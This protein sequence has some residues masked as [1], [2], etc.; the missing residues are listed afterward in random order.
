MTESPDDNPNSNSSDSAETDSSGSAPGRSEL[1]ALFEENRIRLERM[2]EFRLDERL[3]GRVDP[4]DIMQEAFIEADRRF[5]EYQARPAVSFYV[6]LRQI[7]YQ[8]LIDVQRRHFGKK[9]DPRQE[10]GPKRSAGD[11]G[12][13]LCILSAFFSDQ[14]S[15][16]EALMRQEEREQLTLLLEEMDEIDREVLALRHFEQLSNNQIAETLGI[17]ATAASNRY[18]RAMTRLSRIAADRKPEA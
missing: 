10:V 8:C 7:T 1:S 2:L 5:P 6:W 3:R 11:D 14:T 15:P 9:R 12:T 16:S 13:S 4:E 17:S 18:V